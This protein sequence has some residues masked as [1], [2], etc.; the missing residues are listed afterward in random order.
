[1]PINGKAKRV[2]SKV[3]SLAFHCME[4]L[5]MTKD[6]HKTLAEKMVCPLLPLLAPFY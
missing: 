2:V 6:T 4:L 3:I 5:S 1:M